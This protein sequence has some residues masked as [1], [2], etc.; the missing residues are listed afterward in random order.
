[1]VAFPGLSPLPQPYWHSEQPVGQRE[2]L[3]VA[4]EAFE[5]YNIKQ[6]TNIKCTEMA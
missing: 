5:K 6:F 4:S 3:T 1:M 2:N